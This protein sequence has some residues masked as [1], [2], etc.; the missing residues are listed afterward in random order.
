MYKP[1]YWTVI[2]F[3]AFLFSASLT[4]G[5]LKNAS[6]SIL[7][8][9]SIIWVVTFIFGMLFLKSIEFLSLFY[10][11]N[12][13]SYLVISF[14]L[15][16]A[17]LTAAII[18]VDRDY[19]RT[20][21]DR[22]IEA[23][24]L[25]G[26][27]VSFPI[28]IIANAALLLTYSSKS[29]KSNVAR[30]RNDWQAINSAAKTNE[31]R[32]LREPGALLGTENNVIDR[33]ILSML[34]RAEAS[35][36]TS[37]FSILIMIILVCIGGTA[38][39]GTVALDQFSKVRELEKHRG[40]LIKLSDQFLGNNLRVTVTR[41]TSAYEDPYEGS[42]GSRKRFHTDIY[43][44]DSLT[45]ASIKYTLEELYGSKDSYKDIIDKINQ[46]STFSTNEIIMRIS[47]AALTLFLVQVFFHIYRFNQKQATSLFTRSEVFELHKEN[48]ADKK[49]LREI[50]ASKLEESPKFGKSP[51]T[52]IEQVI[53][54]AEKAK[55]AG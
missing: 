6:S 5:Y 27:I 33:V 21:F 24:S 54:I 52:P 34:F 7:L 12:Y 53:N 10:K 23:I 18:S 14:I 16:A 35:V 36:R 47:I 1:N 22:N 4:Y 51:S 42:V 43:I 38:S 31:S 9:I 17:S 39:V 40:N 50:L 28:V 13:A 20:Q 30:M 8:W 32:E 46:Q 29:Y 41:D 2:S 15:L 37:K 49:N 3:F 55:G 48:D 45:L 44:Q 25:Y 11:I 19:S 26:F